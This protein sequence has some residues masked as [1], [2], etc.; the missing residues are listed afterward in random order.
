M[1]AYESWLKD[2]DDLPLARRLFPWATALLLL[3]V[4]AGAGAVWVLMR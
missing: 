3:G 4:F 1:T 2:V